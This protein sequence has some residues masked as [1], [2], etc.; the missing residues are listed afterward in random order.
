ML[1]FYLN[2]SRDGGTGTFTPV[3]GI[4]VDAGDCIHGGVSGTVGGFFWFS[5]C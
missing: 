2:Y 1:V 5:I 3:M 4:Y